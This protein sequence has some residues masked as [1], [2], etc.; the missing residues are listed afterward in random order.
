MTHSI[1]V[2]VTIATVGYGDISPSD[3]YGRAITILIIIAGVGK[4]RCSLCR[5]HGEPNLAEE[6]KSAGIDA[7]WNNFQSLELECSRCS[8]HAIT[9]IESIRKKLLIS[10]TWNSADFERLKNRLENY[11]YC[12]ETDAV[13]LV[14]L[15]ETLSK[16][17][18]SYASS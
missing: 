12:I 1:F 15:K 10:A 5:H 6:R 17:G 7:M 3:V 16:E 11:E 13:N 14:E 8:L 9:C 2:I 4:I 18:V